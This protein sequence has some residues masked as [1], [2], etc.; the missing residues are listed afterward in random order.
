MGGTRCSNWLLNSHQTSDSAG[1]G[2]HATLT[3]SR[4]ET[5]LDIPVDEVLAVRLVPEWS[6][7]RPVLRG[8]MGMRGKELLGF[9]S[10]LLH[11][12]KLSE[13]GG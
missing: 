9:H 11:A 1:T 4:W 2:S 10:R 6:R 8:E 7:L 13:T 5:R 12:A 3:P